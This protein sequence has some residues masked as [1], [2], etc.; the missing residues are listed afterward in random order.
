MQYPFLNHLKML[1]RNAAVIGEADALHLYAHW[2]R[3]SS[4]LGMY[5]WAE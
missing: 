3:R 2:V 5:L 4:T 1:G